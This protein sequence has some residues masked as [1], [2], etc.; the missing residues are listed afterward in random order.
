M[1]NAVD[2]HPRPSPDGWLNL[3]PGWLFASIRDAVI[4][5][6]ADSGRIALWNPAATH[7]LGFESDEVVGRGLGELIHDVQGSLQWDTARAGGAGSGG[8]LE[9]QARRK[10]AS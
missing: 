5:A 8:T 4:V 2:L 7:L 10:D 3:G 6:D 9:L 1:P